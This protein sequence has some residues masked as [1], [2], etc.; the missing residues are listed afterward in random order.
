MG[1]WE[2]ACKSRN[3]AEQIDSKNKNKIMM[4]YYYVCM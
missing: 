1:D 2:I 4:N 3:D